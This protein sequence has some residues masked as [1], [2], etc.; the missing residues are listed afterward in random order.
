M[1]STG[2]YSVRW[3]PTVPGTY[4]AGTRVNLRVQATGSAPVIGPTL[5]AVSRADAGR[6]FSRID[7]RTEWLS[8][9][10]QSG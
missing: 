8:V 2:S 1:T 5:V 10:G 7:S 3:K 6:T 9:G 4:T